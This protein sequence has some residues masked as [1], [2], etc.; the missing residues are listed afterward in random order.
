MHGSLVRLGAVPERSD[1]VFV[2]KL[3]AIGAVDLYFV[4]AAGGKAWKTRDWDGGYA[5]FATQL[6]DCSRLEVVLE[7]AV[8]LRCLG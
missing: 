5:P 8:K 6:F 4:A 1:A 2:A 7:L 3:A